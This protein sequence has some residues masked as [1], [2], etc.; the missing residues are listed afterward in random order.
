MKINPRI[1]NDIDINISQFSTPKGRR[2]II[3]IGEGRAGVGCSLRTANR[4]ARQ[5]ETPEGRR[6]VC[7]RVGLGLRFRV[8]MH[9]G[10]GRGCSR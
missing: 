7:V 5:R 6:G 1:R 2:T 4:S 10:V 3:M 9:A 8:R